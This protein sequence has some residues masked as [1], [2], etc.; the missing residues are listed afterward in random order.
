MGMALNSTANWTSTS[1]ASLNDGALAALMGSE[2][3]ASELGVEP[4]GEVLGSATTGEEPHR[5]TIAPVSAIRKL[6]KRLHLEASQ[7]DLWEINEAFAAM[8]LSVLHH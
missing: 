6:L 5:F 7:V 4:L 2:A 3:M 1:N 8:A